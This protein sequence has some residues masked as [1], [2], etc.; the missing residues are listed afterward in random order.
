MTVGQQTG[1]ELGTD[2]E[3][4]WWRGGIMHGGRA[5]RWD[6]KRW[7]RE[8]KVAAGSEEI[9]TDDKNKSGNAEE[10]CSRIGE[11]RGEQ[12]REKRSATWEELEANYPLINS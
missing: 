4:M 5:T 12:K 10:K 9:K 1:R 8:N 3:K 7:G 6:T 11:D 2:Q